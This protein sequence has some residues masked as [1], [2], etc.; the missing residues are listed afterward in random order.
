MSG[1]FKR[2][3]LR[4]KGNSSHDTSSVYSM[5]SNASF[6]R[7]GMSRELR[8]GSTSRSHTPNTLNGD[9]ESLS[10]R[11]FPSN[12]SDHLGSSAYRTFSRSVRK[13]ST[14]TSTPPSSFPGRIPDPGPHVRSPST[15]SSEPLD[16]DDEYRSVA[17]IRKEMETMEAEGLRLLDAFNGLELSTLTRNQGGPS[18]NGTNVPRSPSTLGVQRKPIDRKSV[19]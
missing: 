15:I 12:S 19:V 10:S 4:R 1:V 14:S 3:S 17:E 2:A 16:E 18:Q 11:L 6:Q 5:G 9:R 8:S 13:L 7:P